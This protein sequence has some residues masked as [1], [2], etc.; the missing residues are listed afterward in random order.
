MGIFAPFSY[1]GQK[2]EAIKPPVQDGLVMWLDASIP[3]SYPG[4]GSTWTDLS[5]EGNNA[6]LVNGVTFDS[7]NGGSLYF[8][9]VDEYGQI[10]DAAELKQADT[11]SISM[12]AKADQYSPT[13]IRLYGKGIY[14]D[15][16]ILVFLLDGY[17]RTL[18]WKNNT[19]IYL[20]TNYKI[21]TTEFTNFTFT[22]DAGNIIRSYFN[23]VAN[24]TVALG[25]DPITYSGTNPYL[26]GA[27]G[28]SKFKGNIAQ[29]LYYDRVITADEALTNFNNTKSRFGL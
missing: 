3:E 9:G 15:G 6:T 28:L 17:I 8:E 29:I 2:A 23:G 16:A 7:A 26:F 19:E 14:Q 22:Y 18:V 1:F 21:S 24:D 25:F 13:W 4:S 5:G 11:L 27:T 12:W 20:N 10:A